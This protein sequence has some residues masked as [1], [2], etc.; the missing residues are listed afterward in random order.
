MRFAKLVVVSAAIS[1]GVC[2]PVWAN[3]VIT[4]TFDGSIQNDSNV[5]AIE[6]AINTAIGKYEADFTDPI[7]VNITFQE[8]TS[9]PL[10][11]SS[12]S[13][14][15][16]S[17]FSYRN[18]LTLDSKTADDT[19]ALAHL[20]SLT[21]FQTF[22]GTS[23]IDVKTANLRAVGLSGSANPDGTITLN[24]SITTPG[25][26]G[27]SGAFD[28]VT[29]TEHEIDE[30][31]GL[32]SVLP[33]IPGNP[34]PEDLF[35]YTAGGARSFDINPSTQAFFSLDGTTDLAQFH[36]QNGDSGDF[37]DWQNA[38]QP[39]VQDWQATGGASPA[40]GVELRALDVI[41]YDLVTAVPEPATGL[42]LTLALLAGL[43]RQR[44]LRI[45]S[46]PSM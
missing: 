46:Q 9:T 37:G 28:L 45:S 1:L 29:V 31:L 22:F 4:P 18:A 12:S 38:I 35:R 11:Q 23:N 16:V 27:S 7:T 39:R 14:G 20:P 3:L 21:Q 10:G 36:Q 43:A 2:S 19:T 34:F 41:G 17:Y 33:N 26:F 6:N 32:G 8:S 44:A 5:T 24:T 30:V 40:L 13:V 25:G 42:L 15:T